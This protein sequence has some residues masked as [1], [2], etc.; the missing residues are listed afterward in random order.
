MYI[1]T[2]FENTSIKFFNEFITEFIEFNT[3][4]NEFINEFTAN[5]TLLFSPNIFSKVFRKV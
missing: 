4:F 3:E 5:I 2:V 1:A